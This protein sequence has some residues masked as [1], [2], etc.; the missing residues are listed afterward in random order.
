[1]DLSDYEKLCSTC[2]EILLSE[3]SS[4]DTIAIPWLHVLNEHPTTLKKYD[5]VGKN[6][7]E[8]GK[9]LLKLLYLFFKNISLRSFPSFYSSSLKI[10]K[11]DTLIISHLL[12]EDQINSKKDFYFGSLSEKLEADKNKVTVLFL[13]H[14]NLTPYE[15]STKWNIKGSERIIFSG[16]LSFS[17]EFKLLF[18]AI[19]QFFSLKNQSRKIV[20]N[21]K[22][23]IYIGASKA[24]LTYE[25]I[26][27]LRF[28]LQLNEL[29]VQIKPKVLLTTLEGHCWERLSYYCAR[30]YNP[31]IKCIGYQHAILFPRQH[32]IMR[33]LSNNFDPDLIFT[34]GLHTKKIMEE[35]CQ[36][37]GNIGIKNIGTHRRADSRVNLNEFTEKKVTPT[38]LVLPDGNHIETLNMCEFA[39]KTAKE[40][41][42]IRFIIRLHPLMQTAFILQQNKD[43]NNIPENLVFSDNSDIQDDFAKCIWALYRG[44]GSA[45]HACI[46]GLK[47]I[48]LKFDD[49]LSIDPLFMVKDGKKN[50]SVIAELEKI[51][52]ED[53]SQNIETFASE[54]NE[55]REY[56]S[57]YFE[58]LNLSEVIKE[59]N[60]DR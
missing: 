33:S 52:I 19:N 37:Y 51:F 10:S 53:L 43:F 56:C 31:S 5:N 4:L 41:K 57:R 36:A 26:S 9:F 21:Y 16:K 38:C 47:P 13:N 58:P 35:R 11:S 60:I 17:S 6:F 18:K 12:N 8:N 24:A 42:N 40:I 2:D 14:T 25:T 3:C 50:I 22:K 48:Y 15:I 34:S 39:L 46:A 45:I 28:I 20:D 1:M 54:L 44:S 29:L 23:R 49:S 7:K 27:S 32:S 59:I 30:R 55:V